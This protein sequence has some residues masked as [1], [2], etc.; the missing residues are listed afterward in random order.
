MG[1]ALLSISRASRGKL[2]ELLITLKPHV[3][4]WIKLCILIYF[5][6]IQPLL[7]KTVTGLLGDFTTGCAHY[8]QV[9]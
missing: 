5:R 2:V 9:I 8:S 4:F 3:I 6:N 1:E 7:Y